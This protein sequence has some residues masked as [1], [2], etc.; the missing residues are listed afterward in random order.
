[1]LRHPWMVEMPGPVIIGDAAAP[2]P[3]PG[4]GAR[5][6][7]CTRDSQHLFT[8]THRAHGGVLN[9]A[10]DHCWAL[11]VQQDLPGDRA[12]RLSEASPPPEPDD[13]KAGVRCC[14]DQGLRG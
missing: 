3:C 2:T 7:G 5:A 4:T 10:R 14:M 11:D 9:R 1:M 13:Q 8:A 12:D 6:P